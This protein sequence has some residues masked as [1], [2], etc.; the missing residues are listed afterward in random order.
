VRVYGDAAVRTI[1]ARFADILLLEA[2]RDA[3][4]KFVD[5]NY[6][7]GVSHADQAMAFREMTGGF[8]VKRAEPSTPERHEL[9]DPRYTDMLTTGRVNAP[10]GGGGG[11]RYAFGFED[12]TINGIRCFGHG[13]GAPGM[14]GDLAI[15]PTTG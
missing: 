11:G 15:C 8:D 3:Y 5:T 7:S 14:N 4:K 1:R 6:P 10:G 2:D 13:G 12:N 9:L